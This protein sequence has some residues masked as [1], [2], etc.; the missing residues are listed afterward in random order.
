MKNPVPPRWARWVFQRLHPEETREEVGGDLDELYDYWYT[1]SGRFC[2]MLRYVL[3]VFSVLPPFVRRRSRIV[4][5]SEP[6][7]FRMTMISN[8][9]K[10]ARRNL[11]KNKMYSFINI[12]GLASGMA[13]AM[14][15]GLWV[16]DELSFNKSFPNHARI[17]Q[18]MQTQDLGGIISTERWVPAPMGR[19]LRLSYGSYFRHIVSS[20]MEENHILAFKDLKFNK[21]GRFMEPGI[22]EMLSLEMVS[23]SRAG[24]L[25]PASILLSESAALSLFGRGNA[26][27]QV[28]KIDNELVAKVT[29]VYRDLPY[30]TTFANTSF[31]AP[32][33][34]YISRVAYG[35]K[36][37]D[38][39]N[40]NFTEVFV[41]LAD[42]TRMGAVSSVIAP[43]R[44]DKLTGTDRATKALVFLQPMD[45]WHL[46]S[47]WKD[48]FNTGG[49]IQYVWLFGIVGVFV[50]VLACINFMNLSTARS[51]K[52][53]REVGVRKAVGSQRGQLVGQFFSESFLVVFIAAVFAIGLAQL[54]MP[55]FNNVADKKMA[56]PWENP[57][58][59]ALVLG[60]CVFTGLLAG[61][62]PAFYLS[63]FKAVN[64]LKGT[65]RAGRLAYIPR[66]VLVVVQFTV[67]VTLIIGTVMVFR[68]IQYTK[69][70][71]VG[72]DRSGLVMIDMPTLDINNHF[73][74]FREELLKT[75]AVVE[76]TKTTTPLT[77]K[78]QNETGFTWRGKDMNRDQPFVTFGVTEEFGKTVGW[79]IKQGRDFSRQYSTDKLAVILNEEAVRFMGLDNPVGETVVWGDQPL[80]VIGV[81]EG[82]VMESPYEPVQH[83]IYY[84]APWPAR[85]VTMRL[86]PG[87]SASDALAKVEKVFW[88]YA[89]AVPFDYRFLD[90]EYD[91]KFRAEE[92]IGKLAGVFTVLAVFISCLGLFGLAS[93]V[94]A[95]RTREIGVRKVLGASV[96]SVWALLSRDF[97]LLVVVAMLIA[98]PVAY[99]ILSSWLEKYE[100]RTGLP[101]SVFV[102]SGA[103]ALLITL[104]TVSFQS[105]TAA[106]VNPVRSLRTD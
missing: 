31:I 56:I 34:L 18:V 70:R 33:E 29:G 97:V 72:Y 90:Q 63:S 40:N 50:L 25:D 99:Y 103:G 49:R 7:N 75:G 88:K 39:W 32:W 16:Y 28:V 69:D 85:V 74:P 15:I 101:W 58:F 64:V 102:L 68:Q 81:V 12:T 60:F 5:Y 82:M 17:A 13:V 80:H 53:A 95:Q 91:A 100:Y 36:N 19:E 6:V 21:P 11:A 4:Q 65:F 73:E 37:K 47:N 27:N 30:N 41:Q 66:Q 42:R 105:I 71:P 98:S 10:V 92:R 57:V 55:Y 2:A 8:Y 1:R 48:G 23:G 104:L 51:E 106:L 87:T 67:S 83:A 78:R 59:W 35:V 93:F 77:E 79:K 22:A 24:L 62:Y 9:F 45:Q 61:S 46:Y 52:R 96:W 14:L 20:T 54:A 26:L 86:R 3:N 38:Q 43:A 94:A 76:V 84:I 44:L 89:P